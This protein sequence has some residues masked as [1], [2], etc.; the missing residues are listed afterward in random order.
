MP[1]WLHITRSTVQL[2]RLRE[3]LDQPKLALTMNAKRG[4][5]FSVNAKLLSP[6]K[7]GED[8]IQVQTTGKIIRF[9]TNTLSELN[10]R[11]NESLAEIWQLTDRELASLMDVIW[12]KET[13]S[14]LHRL[15]DSIALLDA[16]TAMVSYCSLSPVATVRPV[17]NQGGP[18]A[19]KNGHHPI[20]VARTPS[21]AVPNDVFL[22]E[23]S[24]THIVTGRNNA[25]K[26]TFLRSVAL[27][28]ILAHTGCS[29]PAEFASFRYL[30][31]V[32]TRFNTSDD[33][34]SMQSHHSKEMQEIGSILQATTVLS[35]QQEDYPQSLVL[36]DELGRSTNTLDGYSIAY[37]VAERLALCPN[38]LT[39]F[40]THFAALG[41]IRFTLPVVY[42]FHMATR[43]VPGNKTA[44]QQRQ[45]HVPAGHQERTDTAANEG[46][47]T[48]RQ[49]DDRTPTF[50]YK[51]VKGEL[52][53]PHYGIDTARA[54]GFPEQVVEI[55]K[56]IRT[57]LPARRLTSADAFTAAHHA[58][59]GPFGAESKRRC[60]IVRI[61]EQL[62][63]L[64]GSL[65]QMKTADLRKAVCA[66]HQ[67]L[68]A[69]ASRSRERSA[70]TRNETG[71]S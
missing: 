62:S 17:F 68:S 44:G 40:T 16:M 53:D 11:V 43:S 65:D 22:S 5:H 39:L 31:N 55:A 6:E 13:V 46:G 26:S 37:S 41:A 52:Q 29:V 27:N 59:Q 60:N 64:K 38:V 20:L 49:N 23:T 32:C 61:A 35:G 69:T 36:V 67:K 57:A 18:I 25:G 66:L 47:T 7:L 8:F 14:A 1:R 45:Q 2:E 4:Y 9:S 34:N 56:N 33:I 54:A 28:A 71:Q 50:T 12:A 70:I 30:N 48:S 63:H 10:A 24:S 19:I 42:S 3:Q 51:V 15:C 21:D 58:P